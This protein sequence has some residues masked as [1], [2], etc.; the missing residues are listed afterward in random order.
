M[1]AGEVIY[2][3]IRLFG[4]EGMFSLYYTSQTPAIMKVLQNEVWSSCGTTNLYK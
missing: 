2:L 3:K 1:V 4:S